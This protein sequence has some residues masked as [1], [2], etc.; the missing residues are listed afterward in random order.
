[1]TTNIINQT[2]YLRTTRN[3]PEDL[4]QLTVEVNKDHVDIANVVNARTIGL[5]PVNFAAIDGESWFLDNARQQ[6]F[7]QVYQIT[8]FAAIPHN[9]N[10][11]NISFFTRIYGV[12]FVSNI[13]YP[14]PYANPIA[15]GDISIYV[16][17]T[18]IIFGTGVAS[19]TITKGI[20]ILEWISL[21]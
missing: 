21:V 6:G 18:N 16:D 10:L 8:S 7:R 9:L 4:H 15:N 2:A 14:I 19:P 3:F 17:N 12:G 11:D 5:F 20:I 1:M 13:Y